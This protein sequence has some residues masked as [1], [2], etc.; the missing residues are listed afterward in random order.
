MTTVQAILRQKSSDIV[1][2]EGGCS[3]YDALQIMMDKNVS[4]LLILEN[5]KLSGIFTERDYARKIVLQG[6]S[7]KE[8]RI[9]SVMT[10][11]LITV[12]PGEGIERCMQIMTEKRIRHLPVVADTKVIGII[13]IGDLVKQVIEEQQVTI[14]QLQTY[15]SS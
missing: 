1:S 9:R 4:A 11:G 15:I 10:A 14:T 2:V 13:S 3:V 5:G 6:R 8:T 7:S 12:A